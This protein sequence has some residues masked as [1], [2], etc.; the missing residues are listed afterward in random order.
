MCS[1]LHAAS[2]HGAIARCVLFIVF[3]FFHSIQSFY[4]IAFNSDLKLTNW[5]SLIAEEETLLLFFLSL[6]SSSLSFSFPLFPRAE[7]LCYVNVFH[8]SGD[9]PGLPEHVIAFLSLPL[10]L[11]LIC[12]SRT[13]LL[14][15]A[16]IMLVVWQA[17]W[18]GIAQEPQLQ[19]VFLRGLWHEVQTRERI[20]K[21]SRRETTKAFPLQAAFIT[22]QER[23]S[24]PCCFW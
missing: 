19:P 21:Q 9:L 22:C 16:D 2:K 18:Q 20:T 10:A 11:S 13:P 14:S 7:C 6:L 5:I 15:P 4:L 3:V 24:L 23:I 8:H 17:S 1:F 12:P